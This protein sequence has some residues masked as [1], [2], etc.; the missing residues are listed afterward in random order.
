MKLPNIRASTRAIVDDDDYEELMKY[1][2]RLS[3]HGYARSQKNKINVFMHRWILKAPLYKDNRNVETDHINGKKLDNRK[4]NLRLCN[5]SENGKNKAVYKNNRLGIKGVKVDHGRYR[6]VISVSK[7]N[8][9]S[10]GQFDTV[11]EAANAYKEAQKR[12]HGT[13]AKT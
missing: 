11:L 10:L 7:G 9:I 12:Y 8:V 4:E 13:F 2:W 5:H 6:A 1:T 3:A